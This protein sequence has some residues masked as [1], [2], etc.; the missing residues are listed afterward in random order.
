MLQKGALSLL[1]HADCVRKIVQEYPR[2]DNLTHR[3]RTCVLCT[4]RTRTC[5]CCRK[6]PGFYCS[7]KYLLEVNVRESQ[8]RA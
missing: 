8:F 7:C 1:F 6:E 5:V 4:A 2:D 3:M